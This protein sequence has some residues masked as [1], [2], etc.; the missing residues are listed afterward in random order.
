[1]SGHVVQLSLPDELAAEIS[2]AVNRGE[3]AN[4]SDAV[5]GAIEEWPAHRKAEAI[6]V[7][8]LERL[9]S[10][11]IASGPGQFESF[12]DIRGEARRRF[13]GA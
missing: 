8:T 6:A 10:E 13:P 3:Y 4:A 11:G 9:V 12:E 5:L 1:M 7:E 2:E